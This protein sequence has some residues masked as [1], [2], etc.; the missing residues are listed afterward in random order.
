M[1]REWK[2]NMLSLIRDYFCIR[3]EIPQELSDNLTGQY[4]SMKG[5][6]SSLLMDNVYNE[7]DSII[8]RRE[9]SFT[10]EE[11]KISDEDFVSE[12]TT[13]ITINYQII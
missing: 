9:V 12:F 10:I 1:T 8:D 5:K 7:S 2:M 11:G 4:G 3:W 6:L 13:T